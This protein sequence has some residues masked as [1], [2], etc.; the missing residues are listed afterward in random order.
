MTRQSPCEK[1]HNAGTSSAKKEK[2]S[3]RGIPASAFTLRGSLGPFA[4]LKEKREGAIH[5]TRQRNLEAKRRGRNAENKKRS[6]A[7]K[8]WS[9]ETSEL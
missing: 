2:G 6:F 4:A 7:K 9:R 3:A 5:L 1:R 8:I